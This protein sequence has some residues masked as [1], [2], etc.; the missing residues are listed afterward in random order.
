MNKFKKIT[1]TFFA[2]L[3]MV[4]F[5]IT[6]FLC[7]MTFFGMETKQVSADGVDYDSLE[8]YDNNFGFAE[9]ASFLVESNVFNIYTDKSMR[10]EYRNYNSDIFKIDHKYDSAVFTFTIV[11]STPEA[12]VPIYEIIVFRQNNCLGLAHK[13]LAVDA[14]GI[15]GYD[16]EEMGSIEIMP[17]Q[18][19]YMETVVTPRDYKNRWKLSKKIEYLNA[20]KEVADYFEGKGYTTDYV[21]CD[22]AGFDDIFYTEAGEDGSPAVWLRLNLNSI[23]SEYFVTSTYVINQ[24]TGTKWFKKQY[25]KYAGTLRSSTRSIYGILQKMEEAGALEEELKTDDL[26][27]QANKILENTVEKTVSVSYLEQIGETPFAH[28]VEKDVTIKMEDGGDIAYDDIVGALGEEHL[29][30]AGA[31]VEKFVY[32]SASDVYEAQYLSPTRVE[33]KTVDGNRTDYFLTFNKSFNSFVNGIADEGAFDE[34]FSSFMLNEIKGKYPDTAKY[35]GDDLYGLFGYVVVPQTTSFNSVFADIF[36]LPEDWT[37]S[38]FNYKI[39]GTLSVGTYQALL[40]E[41]NYTWL[42][43]I[44]QTILTGTTSGFSLPATHYLFY[45]DPKTTEVNI[46][47]NNGAIGEE[48]GAITETAKDVSKEIADLAVKVVEQ[49]GETVKNTQESTARTVKIIGAVALGIIAVGALVFVVNKAK[50]K[51]NG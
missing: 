15:S 39:T 38:L 31:S 20:Y 3:F 28:K 45:A 7:G 17:E 43:T 36:Q 40:K 21:A 44:W 14:T 51:A 26:I 46:G 35:T 22:V 25:D 12:N 5:A 2:M 47:E 29:N 48:D 33:A 32:N 16:P 50:G 37:G 18:Y 9:G 8:R 27:Y 30:V 23:Y 49:L 34:E 42:Q 10:F 19:E 13:Q 4:A 24:Y 11:R 1:S 41:H 6:S